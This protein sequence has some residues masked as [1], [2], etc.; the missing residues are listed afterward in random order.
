MNAPVVLEGKGL[1]V[2]RGGRPVLRG[3]DLAL[4]KGRIYGILG[5]SGAGKTTLVRALCGLLPLAK[6]TLSFPG[7]PG[8]ERKGPSGRGRI[9]PRGIVQPL[10]Q[11]PGRALNPRKTV[12]R[13]LEDSFRIRGETPSKASLEGA[14]L[15]AGLSPGL[16]ERFPPELS[17]GER[18][19][20]ALARV[21]ALEPEILLLDE[22][23]SAL[24]PPL[25]E[26][27][28]DLVQD[29]AG[30]EGKGVLL[31]THDLGVVLGLAE[32]MGVLG[33]GW[34]LEWGP[35]R[36]VFDGP[37]HPYTAALVEAFKN[38]GA[39]PPSWTLLPPEEK[40]C[41]F[42]AACPR[43]GKICA[44]RRPPFLAWEGGRKAGC[45]RPLEG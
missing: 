28:G 25:R 9:H 8:A 4:R 13:H 2:E 26:E 20:A 10:F 27:M 24:D 33:W 45:H 36:E 1:E 29:L 35:V 6:G 5:P 23:F 19:R 41:P 30:K 37:L 15:R 31:V 44:E 12:G 22:P 39:P 43:A 40:G 34:F 3:V 14:A 32:E 21:L 7:F 16:L 42:H 38:P 11:D 18:Q 17:G